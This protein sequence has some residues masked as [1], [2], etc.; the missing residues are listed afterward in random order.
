MRYNNE[1]DFQ[2]KNDNSEPHIDFIEA[3]YVVKNYGPYDEFTGMLIEAG[4]DIT[5][6]GEDD[7]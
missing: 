7:Q 4:I 3:R 2:N 6:E 1:L 5:K